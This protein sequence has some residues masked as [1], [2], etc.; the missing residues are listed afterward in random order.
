MNNINSSIYHDRWVKALE[1]MPNSTLALICSGT[2]QYRNSDVDYPFRGDSNFQYLCGFI[3]PNAVLALIKYNDNIYSVFFCQAKNPAQEIWHGKR[4]GPELAKQNLGFDDAYSIDDINIIMPNLLAQVEHCAIDW[5]AIYDH[6]NNISCREMLFKWMNSLKSLQRKGHKAP[7][8]ILNM[9]DTLANMRLFKDEN[10]QSIMQK[11]AK[12]SAKGHIAAMQYCA[13]NHKSGLAEYELEAQLL[14]T[15][16]Q[17]GAQ[18]V[19]YNS[20]VASHDNACILHHRAGNRIMHSSELCLIDAACELNGYASDI[21]RTF[22]V[23]G[24]FSAAQK[25]VYNIVLDAQ[26]AAIQAC[27]NGN[28]FDDVHMAALYVLVDGMLDIG[29]IKKSLYANAHDAINDNAYQPFYM[30]R[31]SH[32]IGLDVHDVGNY[33]QYSSLKSTSQT[34]SIKTNFNISEHGYDNN[35]ILNSLIEEYSSIIL[36]DNMALTIEPGIYIQP[37]Y[38]IDEQYWNIGIRIEDDVIVKDNNCLILTRDVPVT[39]HEIEYLMKC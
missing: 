24:V 22:P 27:K 4:C 30:H 15:F 25:R 38:N 17:H 14:H 8:S 9:A 36:Q 18:N 34:S 11:A 29:L 26:Q 37:H 33:K 3:E 12:I 31:T 21:T 1:N 35:K 20:I 23:N 5:L 16:M 7:H 13:K 6:N 10:E 32:W 39:I 2:T 19:A 28:T